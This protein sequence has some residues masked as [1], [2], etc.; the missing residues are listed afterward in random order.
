MT[1]KIKGAGGV[2]FPDA[3]VQSSAAD[4]GPA[5]RATNTGGVTVNTTA[6]IAVTTEQFDTANCYD[7]TLSRFTPNVA[8]YY[9]VEGVLSGEALPAAGYAFAKIYKNGVLVTAGSSA[10]V[11]GQITS[12][13]STNVA[14]LVFMNGTTDYLELWSTIILSPS[15]TGVSFSGFLARRAA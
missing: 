2:E 14:A 5:F 8:G 12:Y 6:K 1:T 4:A 13:F 3:S 9:H 7:T 11:Q 15:I 10:G